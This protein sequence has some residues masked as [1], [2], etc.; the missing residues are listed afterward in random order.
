MFRQRHEA[1]GDARAD[2]EAVLVCRGESS[3]SRE[4][5]VAES[6]RVTTASRIG[7]NPTR[8]PH[9]LA[10]PTQTIRLPRHEAIY[11]VRGKPVPPGPGCVFREDERSKTRS[12]AIPPCREVF[13]IGLPW[14]GG[15][16]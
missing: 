15:H 4:L 16:L 7:A 8:E 9:G 13:E 11:A 12:E 3:H 5:A 6:V 10:E 2:S 14:K 1:N